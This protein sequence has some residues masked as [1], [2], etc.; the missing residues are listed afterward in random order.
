MSENQ[1]THAVDQIV[2]DVLA[3]RKYRSVCADTVR[4]FAMGEWARRGGQSARRAIKEATKATRSRLHQAYGA[5]ESKIDYGRA[6]RDLEAAYATGRPEEVRSAC[7][8]LLALHAST[9]ERLPILDRLYG[10][11]FARTG[12][13]DVLLDLACGLNPLS[14]PWMGLG[15]GATYYAY[16][17]D[18]ERTDLLNRYL[19]LSDLSGGAHFQDILTQPPEEP[20][21][22][23][24]LL[25]SSAC[26]ERQCAGAT[27]ALLD[28]LRVRHVA[29]SFPVHSLGGHDKGMPEQYERTFIEMLSG[30]PW[31]VTHLRFETELVFLV[32]KG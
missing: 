30:R 16:D 24:L 5:Y 22:V 31:P 26:L 18:G 17:I 28:A 9:R 10:E 11:V 12:L 1:D 23:A 27:L 25:K 7:R 19:S 3:A 15:E 20:G 21:D 14:L 4:R 2:A 8:R 13:P 6:Y 29:V 32:D